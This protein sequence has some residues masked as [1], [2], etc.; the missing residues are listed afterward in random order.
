[1]EGGFNEAGQCIN[2]DKKNTKT[3]EPK[4]DNITH[5]LT[6]EEVTNEFLNMLT[7]CFG[8]TKS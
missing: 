4:P 6:P 8:N 5:F 1:M 2:D 7:E 3:K